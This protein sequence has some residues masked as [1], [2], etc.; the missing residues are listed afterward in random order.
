MHVQGLPHTLINYNSPTL[1]LL[2]SLCLYYDLYVY[3]M[4]STCMLQSICVCY[5][6]FVF[7]TI[8]MCM[9][10]SLCIFTISMCMQ[11]SLCVNYDLYVSRLRFA[12]TRA[13]FGF[14]SKPSSSTDFRRI[15]KMAPTV[16]KW[17]PAINISSLEEVFILIEL[18]LTKPP[19]SCFCL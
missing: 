15:L 4:I 9:L 12:C 11:W 16:G 8:S 6:L 10:R 19:F 2:R 3:T 13:S 18:D 14:H 17:T 1:C 5:D 7:G